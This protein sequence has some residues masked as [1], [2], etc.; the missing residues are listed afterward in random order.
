MS[1]PSSVDTL[2]ETLK[3]YL[4]IRMEHAKF[5]C[6]E[7]LSV[8]L[9]ASAFLLIA[10]LLGVIALGYFSLAAVHFLEMYVGLVGAY[11]IA[12]GFMIVLILVLCRLRD[13]WILDPIARFLSRVL[14]NDNDEDNQEL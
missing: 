10:I 13:R 12:G 9:S 11:A 4:G 1:Q 3:R 7:K 6:A 2:I 5:L 14:L 8:I